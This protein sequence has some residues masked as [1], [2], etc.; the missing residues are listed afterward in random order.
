MI[1]KSQMPSRIL[2][3]DLDG[4][5]TNTEIDQSSYLCEDPSRYKISKYNLDNLLSVLKKFDDTRIVISSNW[6]RFDSKNPLW[7]YK[8]KTYFGLL[9]ET[10]KI[11]KK[12]IVD[13]LP[14]D[15][16]ITKSEAM[17]LWFEDNSWFKKNSLTNKYVIL[18]DDWR[19]GYLEHPIFS[20]HLVYTD[21][22]YGFDQNDI[23][24]ACRILK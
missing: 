4:V 3:L 9:P 18:D 22:K 24:K 21:V 1:I 14:H 23:E 15:R 12:W 13:D 11:L 20:K 5:L 10:R 16:H 2:F 8:G 6:R 19:E 17:E 7:E